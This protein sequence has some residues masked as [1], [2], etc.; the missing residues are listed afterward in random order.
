MSRDA[1]VRLLPVDLTFGDGVGYGRQLCGLC[2]WGV[3]GMW[4]RSRG[5]VRVVGVLLGA[6]LAVGS[7]PA[8]TGEAVADAPDSP[9][10]PK[11]AAKAAAHGDG[12]LTEAEALAKAK[13]TGEPVEVVSL[14]GEAS[15]VFATPD[16]RLQARE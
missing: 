6:V 1:N 7:T 4:G 16:G 13:R 9:V 10:S 8:L 11:S 2:G 15:E 5:S 3:A 12:G 14:R